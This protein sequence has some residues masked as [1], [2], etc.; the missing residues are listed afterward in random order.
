MAIGILS[1]GA[2]DGIQGIGPDLHMQDI[3]GW[4]LITMEESFLT[5]FGMGLVGE[6]S[7]ITDGII[8]DIGIFGAT[9]TIGITATANP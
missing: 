5:G 6:L 3:D 7:M 8:T 2:I 4:L 1:E 9:I